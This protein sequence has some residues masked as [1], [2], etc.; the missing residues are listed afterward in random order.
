MTDLEIAQKAQMLPIR[1]VAKK[2]NISEDD[3]NPYG[4][5]KAKL[6]L[7]LINAEKMKNSKLVLVTAITPTPAGEGKTTVSIG[8]TEGLNKIGKKANQKSAVST[9]ERAIFRIF[10]MFLFALKLNALDDAADKTKSEHGKKDV[11]T[12][13][14]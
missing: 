5:Y 8:L 11:V 4:K 2:L 7:H 14:L 1:E 10:L 12:H 9:K 3:L 6:P 13:N